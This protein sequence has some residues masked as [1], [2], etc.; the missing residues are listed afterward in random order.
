MK[1]RLYPPPPHS[2]QYEIYEI[3]KIDIQIYE[4]RYTN[5]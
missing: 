2:G 4:Y 3:D 5:I 1:I